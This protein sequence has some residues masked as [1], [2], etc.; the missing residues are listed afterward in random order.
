MVLQFELPHSGTSNEYQQH[1][2]YWE[3][4]QCMTKPTKWHVCPA[5]TQISL[6]IHPDWSVF[7]VCMKK[8]WVHSYPLSAWQR[9]LIRLGKCPGW[10]ESSLGAH[11]ILLDL[12]CAGSNNKNYPRIMIGMN[13]CEF[14]WCT[15]EGKSLTNWIKLKGLYV[16]FVICQQS[17]INKI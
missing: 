14:Y 7:A 6:G 13:F 5:K 3:M 2:F 12:S 9:L 8:V 16:K 15:N 1:M 4:S 17:Q 10:S 11:V